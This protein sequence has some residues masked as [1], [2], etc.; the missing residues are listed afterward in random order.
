M[1]PTKLL[2]GQILVLFAIV[3]AGSWFATEW[4]ASKPNFQAQLGRSRFI[5]A[6]LPFHRPWHLFTWWFWYDDCAPLTS[7]RAF[8]VSIGV[9]GC[10]VPIVGSLWPAESGM[11][12]G[13]ERP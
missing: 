9:A 3:S 11:R 8:A 6:G 5:L 13:R 4:C 12:R 7:N 10:I 1:T 2:I